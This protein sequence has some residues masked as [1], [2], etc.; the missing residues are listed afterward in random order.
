MPSGAALG[1]GSRSVTAG[2]V[3]VELGETVAVVSVAVRRAADT[4]YLSTCIE[5]LAEVGHWVLVCGIAI[6]RVSEVMQTLAF[7]NNGLCILCETRLP[8][9]SQVSANFLYRKLRPNMALTMHRFNALGKCALARSFHFLRER[10]ECLLR[11][12]TSRR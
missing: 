12:V 8:Y 5:N 10:R 2:D 4:N 6:C 1:W 7:I 3:M 9:L 11:Q